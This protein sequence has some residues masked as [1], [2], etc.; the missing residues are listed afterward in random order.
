MLLLLVYDLHKVIIE[1]LLM[2]V[3][4][5]DTVCQTMI[6]DSIATKEV[7]SHA[8]SHINLYVL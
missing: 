8:L 5:D 3:S 4:V 7:V 6:N 2:V 1:V